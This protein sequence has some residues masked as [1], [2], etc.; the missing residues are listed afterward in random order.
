MSEKQIAELV[1]RILNVKVLVSVE[2]NEST[3]ELRQ[4]HKTIGEV[5]KESS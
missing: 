5:L 3:C 4:V 2:F 1:A